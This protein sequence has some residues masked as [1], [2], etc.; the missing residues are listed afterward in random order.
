MRK[1]TSTSYYKSTY[2]R[3]LGKFP[4]QVSSLVH[5]MRGTDAEEVCMIA[6]WLA[7]EGVQPAIPQNPSPLGWS[8]CPFPQDSLLTFGS[9]RTTK[10]SGECTLSYKIYRSWSRGHGSEAARSAPAFKGASAIF[11]PPN[12][13]SSGKIKVVGQVLLANSHLNKDVDDT[14]RLAALESFRADTGLQGLLAYLVQWI[15]E[16]VG[17]PYHPGIRHAY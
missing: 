5:S 8:S 15:A 17:L 6:H 1:S 3:Y 2:H 9:G 10:C 16:K 7:V 14:I 4:I 13:G 12:N 11:R